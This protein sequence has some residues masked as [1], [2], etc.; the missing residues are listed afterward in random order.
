MYQKG[1]TKKKKILAGIESKESLSYDSSSPD[2]DH[3][4][5]KNIEWNFDILYQTKIQS[6]EHFSGNNIHF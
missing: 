5:S 6:L 1:E 3:Y 4:R 2:L